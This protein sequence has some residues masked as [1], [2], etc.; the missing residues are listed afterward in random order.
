MNRPW[1]AGTGRLDAFM[2]L[3]RRV[4]AQTSASPSLRHD[5]NRVKQPKADHISRV[6]SSRVRTKDNSPIGPYATAAEFSRLFNKEAESLYL[7]AFQLV[8]DPALAERCFVHGFEDAI[9]GNPVFKEWAHSWAR[10]AIITNAIQAVHPRPNDQSDPSSNQRRINPNPDRRDDEA[11]LSLPAFERF[12]FVMSILENYSDQECS[13][14]LGVTRRDVIT[15][16]TAA[17]QRLETSIEF[18][19]NRLPSVQE[20]PEEFR[21]RKSAVFRTNRFF[22]AGCQQPTLE[23]RTQ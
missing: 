5:M 21:G 11:V 7:L 3:L 9:G 8:A 17:L 22:T 4:W 14:L 10:R 2:D 15:A 6:R 19:R 16:R 1:T 20:S 13:L 23:I 18:Q 12:A